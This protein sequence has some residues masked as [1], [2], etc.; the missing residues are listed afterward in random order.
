MAQRYRLTLDALKFCSLVDEPAQP[1]AKILAFKS[2]A[3]KQEHVEATAKFLKSNDDLGLAFFWAFTSTN[4]DGSEHYDLQGDTIDKNFMKAAMEW[5]LAGAP[6]DEMHDENATAAKTVFAMPM[7]PEIASFYG[8]TTKQSGLMIAIKPTE[9]QLAKLK[10]GTYTGVSIGGSGFR[11]A[12]KAKGST[13]KAR[14]AKA[15]LYTDEVEGHAH[16]IC[17]SDEGEMWCSYATMAGAD[18]SHSHGV[19]R[20]ANGGLLILADSGHSHELAAGQPV[21]VAVPEGAVIVTMRANTGSVS[22]TTNRAAAK[23]AAPKSTPSTALNKVADMNDAEKILELTK[24]L[25]RASRI[26]K[27]SGAHKT[28]F[29]ATPADEQDAFLAKSNSERDALLAASIEKSKAANEV[30]YTSKSTGETYAKSDDVRLVAMAK[31]LDEQA[32]EVEKAD[33]RK[34]AAETLGNVAG[35]EAT[36]D[37][38]V[39]S[40]RKGGGSKEVI[41]AAIKTLKSANEFAK[42]ATRAAGFGGTAPSDNTSAFEKF[43]TALATF[44]KSVS[45]TPV[46]ATADFLRTPEGSQ[47][48]AATSTP[49]SA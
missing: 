36:H 17:L 2:K 25:D 41:E 14:V 43:N 27:L 10:D 7:D 18:C 49:H 12:V 46:Q 42:T 30:V 31:R 40:I 15:E 1:N 45:K 24:S 5:C 33:I 26:A 47:L 21:V 39:K 29:D 48:Y 16:T 6:I 22:P 19:T 13:L 11:E 8:I 3:G 44:A 20:D 38:I 4:P 9:D 32:E 28:L 37:Y 35:D 34:A 23:A